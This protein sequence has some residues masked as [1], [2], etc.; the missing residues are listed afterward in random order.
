MKPATAEV[1]LP[2]DELPA[3]G[4]FDPGALIALFV[5]TLRQHARGR[6]LLILSL[7]FLLPAAL[8][9]MIKLSAPQPPLP[10]RL[11]FIF[12]FNLI[13]Y[14][15]VPLTALLYAAGMIQDEVEEQTLTYLLLR[16][17]PRWALYLTKLVATWVVTSLLTAVFTTLT[18]AIV[19]WGTPELWE[20]ILP[21]RAAKTAALMSFLQIGYCSFFG[22]MGLFTRRTLIIGLAYI[23]G[24]EG[25]LSNIEMVVRQL[26]VMYYFRVLS[27]RWLA[28]QEGK[29]WSKEW[30][31]NLDDAPSVTNCI[32]RVLVVSAVLTILGM[33]M[34]MRQEFRMK[35]PEG[36]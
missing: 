16:P 17:L 31:I 19:W 25:L 5:L 18:F 15:L 10:E 3:R 32:E 26:T 36:N 34:M 33:M 7:L 14:A 30:G 1:F 22:A 20:S 6:R 23:V 12:I 11:E 2:P 8:V 29:T 35:T 21:L 28:P 24:F 9:A 13:P 27:V 4:G